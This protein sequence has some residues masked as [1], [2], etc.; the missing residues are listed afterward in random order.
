MYIHVSVDSE[1]E[2]IPLKLSWPKEFFDKTAGKISPRFK[3][4]KD[5]SDYQMMIDTEL[6]KINEIFKEY[7]LGSKTLTISQLIRD[8]NSFTSRKDFFTFA[9]ND[10]NERYKRKKIELGTRKGN[11]ASITT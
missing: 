1:F 6:G 3:D 10:I 7:R 9:V 11:L 5:C 2:R 4:D 8:Y